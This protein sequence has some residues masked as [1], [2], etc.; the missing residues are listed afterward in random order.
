MFFLLYKTTIFTFICINDE[1]M[2]TV[3]FKIKGSI[4]EETE[5]LLLQL[6]KPWNNYINEALDYYNS[7]QKQSIL[8]KNLNKES[9]L[10]KADLLNIL[11]DFEGID[12]AY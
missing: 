5:K 4:F 6:K 3:S 12:Y 2:K 10:V 8:E 7:F 11:E 1:I 9:D